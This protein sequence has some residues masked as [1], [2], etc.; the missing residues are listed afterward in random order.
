MRKSLVLLTVFAVLAALA[1]VPAAA[2]GK[3]K[4]VHDS[5]AA[6]AIPFPNL[7]SSTGTPR[8]GCSAGEE[9]VHWVGH[10]LK[11]PFSGELTF[12]TDGFT[13]DWDLYVYDGDVPIGR[14]DSAQVGEELAPPEEEVTLAMK[15]GQTFQLVAC[16]W[17]GE[18]Q[19][20]AHFDL[21]SK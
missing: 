9:G 17:F 12:Y 1:S 2:A 8:P 3:K 13:G 4:T 10:E 15:K 20:E 6:Q 16:N 19:I 7:S 18:P 14:S 5:F 21:V 11:A